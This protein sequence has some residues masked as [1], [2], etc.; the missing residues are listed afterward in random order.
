MS[1]FWI[2]LG[3]GLSVLPVVVLILLGVFVVISKGR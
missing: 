1:P 2:G 3:V